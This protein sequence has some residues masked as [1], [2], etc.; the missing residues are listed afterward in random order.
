MC[1]SEK[2]CFTLKVDHK[3]SAFEK[4]SENIWAQ[5]E[6]GSREFKVSPNVKLTV[7]VGYL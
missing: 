2:G 7:F 1:S 3:S 6:E 4:M 5:A